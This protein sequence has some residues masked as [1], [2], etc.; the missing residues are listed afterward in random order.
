MSYFR[1]ATRASL[2]ASLFAFLLAWLAVL[3]SCG[4]GSSSNSASA[5]PGTGGTGSFTIGPISGFGSVIINGVRYADSGAVVQTEDGDSRDD[6]KGTLDLDDL[7]LGMITS[8]VAGEETPA[9]TPTGLATASASIFYLSNELK[10]PVSAIDSTNNTM[11]VLQQT[12]R[13]TAGTVFG[14]VSGLSQ[15]NI[16]GNCQYADIYAYYN[17][18]DNS[19]TATRVECNASIPPSFRIFG[20]ASKV[21]ANGFAINGLSISRGSESLAGISDGVLVRAQLGTALAGFKNDIATATRLKFNAPSAVRKFNEIEGE[22]KVEG[23]IDN[24]TSDAAFS[25]NGVPVVTTSS[26]KFK[27]DISRPLSLGLRIEVEGSVSNGLLMAREID[28]AEGKDVAETSQFIGKVSNATGNSG[29][30]FT[31]TTTSRQ[32]K[33]FTVTYTASDF[34]ET[35]DKSKFSNGVNVEVKGKLSANGVDLDATSLEVDD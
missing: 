9:T 25:V 5:S 13:T 33:V 24:Y 11:K 15:A 3:S 23:L 17:V 1:R 20:P 21:S 6:D 2:R 12:V 28:V 4:G 31:L 22:A 35:S 7:K 16:S 19:Y 10:G 27:D 26:T 30:T 14:N 34:E 32:S 18:S 29:G 8:V